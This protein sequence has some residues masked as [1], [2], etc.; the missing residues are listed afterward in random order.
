[1]SKK[2]G[3]YI[4]IQSRPAKAAAA[5]GINIYCPHLTGVVA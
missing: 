1:M 2:W 5:E 3:Q 4:F